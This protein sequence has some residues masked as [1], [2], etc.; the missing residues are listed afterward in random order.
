MAILVGC[1][2]ETPSADSS[3]LP[4]STV[5]TDVPYVPTSP[6]VVTRML[7][8]A[9]VNFDDV[10][11]DLGSGDGRIVI[12]AAQRYR[13]RGVGIEIDPV[14]VW[15]ARENAEAAGVAGRVEFRQKDLFE[16]DISEATVVTLYLLPGVNRKL[17]PQLFDQLE[18]GT[19]VVSHNFDMGNWPPDSTETVGPSTIYLWTIPESI[20]E[21]LKPEKEASLG[22]S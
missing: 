9:E 4:D 18:P 17:R 2:E 1:G 5:E 20:S 15:E 16:A 12:T 3:P 11:Y 8:M 10:V 19:R 22:A 14:R 13:A 6:D 7:E 21:S